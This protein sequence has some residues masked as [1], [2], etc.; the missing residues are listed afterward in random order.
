MISL[1]NIRDNKQKICEGLLAKNFDISIIDVILEKDSIWRNGISQV[2][3]LKEQRN[4]ASKEISI[5][6]KEKKNTDVI[7]EKMQSVS[8]EIKEIDTKNNEIKDEIDSLILTVPNT[9]HISVPIGKDESSNVVI[10]EWGEKPQFDFTIEGHSEIAQKLNL[11]DF[12]VG[13]LISGSGFP[14][15]FGLGAKLERSLIN[16][17]LDI[18]T[19]NGY[20]ETFPPFMVNR[21]SMQT[22]GQL[23]KFLDDMYELPKDELF[24]IPT[25]EVPVTNY[26]RDQ[27]VEEQNLPIKFAAYSACFRR[28][29]GSY[30]KD[31]RGL[32]RLHQ[33]NKVELVKFSNPEESYNELELLLSDAEKILQFLGLHYRV[34]ELCSGDLSFSASKC[35]DIEVWSPFEEKYLEV[36]SCSNFEDFQSYRGNMR[37]RSAKTGKMEFLHTLNGSGLATPRLMVALLENYQSQDGSVAIPKPLKEYMGMDCISND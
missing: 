36:S 25:A 11:L 37:F 10:K 35:Y 31:T 13:S 32:L 8:S 5:F 7:I 15:Y 18:H 16:F 23:P 24:A 4:Q 27:L 26:Y 1:K 9:P 21:D 22:T 30:G 29:A 20:K 28:E 2:E 17:M 19:D 33:F 14:V 34:I 3:K 6:K 12:K